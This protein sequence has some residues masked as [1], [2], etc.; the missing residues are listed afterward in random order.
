MT[1]LLQL[2]QIGSVEEY[3]TQFQNLQYGVTM[4][5]ANYDDMFFTQHYIMGLREDI[6][7]MVEAQMPTTVLTASTLAKVQQ[8]VLERSKTKA[9]KPPYQPRAYNQQKTDARP[10]QH[11]SNLWQDRQLRDYRRNNGLC[12]YCGD[13]FVPGHI[14]VCSKR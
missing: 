13:K 4:H 12:F 10:Q 1:E 11:S 5:N 3:T 6:R 14:E 7:G 9:F 2:K 8:K